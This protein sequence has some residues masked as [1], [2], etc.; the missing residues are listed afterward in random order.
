MEQE[1]TIKVDG[2]EHDLTVDTRTT[3]LDALREREERLQ[4][5]LQAGRMGNWEWNV[6][7]NDVTWS[8]D[9]EAIHGLASGEENRPSWSRTSW[10]ARQ[11]YASATGS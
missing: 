7:T 2:K 1:I 4:I 6:R 10:P 8:P 5:A 3:L 11:T 9:V